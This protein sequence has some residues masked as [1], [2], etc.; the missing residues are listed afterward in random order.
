MYIIESFSKSHIY[1]LV[2]QKYSQCVCE[3]GGE[4]ER[5]AKEVM[6]TK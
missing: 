5:E 2:V 6:R 3:R 1:H 4:K